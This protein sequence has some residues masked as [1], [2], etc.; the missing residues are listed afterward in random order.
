MLKTIG[1][2]TFQWQ[3]LYEKVNSYN[4]N[5]LSRPM[6]SFGTRAKV[7][8]NRLFAKNKRGKPKPFQDHAI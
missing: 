7:Q 1:I 4:S 8:R 3:R 5:I 2:F 6:L